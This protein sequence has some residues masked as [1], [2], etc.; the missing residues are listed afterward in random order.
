M[1]GVNADTCGYCFLDLDL[2]NQRKK[3]ATCAAF[4]DANNLTF[5]LSSKSLLSL[6]GSEV[7]R[8]KEL[9]SSDHE[10]AARDAECGGVLTRPTMERV[11]VMLWWNVAPL[12]CQNF[13]TLCANGSLLP[14]E[15]G[16]P[17][18]TPVGESGKPLS[19]RGSKIHR[20]IPGFILQGGDFVLGNGSGGESIF[21]KKVFKDER[22][23]LQEKH[24]RFGLLS[25]GNS[26]KNSNSSQ[27]FFTLDKAPQCDG[28]HVVFGECVS[29][30][31]VLKA[32]EIFGTASGEPSA[33]I[34]ITD[35]GVFTPLETPGA[36]YWFDKPDANSWNGISPTFVV[37]PRVAILAPN[38][39]VLSKFQGAA[40]DLL[41]LEHLLSVATFEHNQQEVISKLRGLLGSFS[42]DVVVIA[43]ACKDLKAGIELPNAWKSCGIG[44]DEVLLVSKPVDTVSVIHKKS[45]LAKRK[46]R[47][48]LD[49]APS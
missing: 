49:E 23:G 40:S 35:C 24:D 10:W 5:G 13:A 28:K 41:A 7:S 14:G 25:M 16:K 2:D 27:F 9:I 29:G 4:V 12:A 45:W 33:S 19:Y 15:S 47:W 37:R 46:G 44:I 1:P 22:K 38:E 39:A 18:P 8:L 34:C 48:H 6:G 31:Q 21:N 20:C 17:K 42:I 3:L 26:G 30:G 32:A 36:G 11:V 43:P